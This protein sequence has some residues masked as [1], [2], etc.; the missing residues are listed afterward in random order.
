M[1]RDLIVV[2]AGGFGRETLDVVEA[3]NTVE[4]VPEWNVLGVVDDGPAET[5][6][7]RLEARGY[8]HL[9]G[10]DQLEVHPGAAVV[11]AIG[12]PNVR[13]RIASAL[14]ATG[15]VFATLVHPR[16]VVGSQVRLGVG[17]VVCGGAQISTNVVIRAHGHINPGAVIGHDTVLGTHVSVNPG[18][19]VSGEVTIGRD[20]LVGAGAVILQRL[21]LGE[22]VTVGASA[23]VTRDVESGL[24]VK[25]VPA[26]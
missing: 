12:A 22:N 9:G 21:R 19:I 5:H 11:I 18:A 7:S 10:I 24:V 26:Q 25:G 4:P 3:I 20:T 6:L 16:A 15:V 23:C 2:G 14:E 13:A 8:R 1:T 17:T